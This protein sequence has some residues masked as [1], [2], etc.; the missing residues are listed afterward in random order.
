MSDGFNPQREICTEKY[1]VDNQDRLLKKQK[2][3]DKQNREKIKTRKMIYLN[4]R[5]K[6]DLN[7]C[8]ICKTRSRIRQALQGKTKSSSTKKFLGKDVETY[9]NGIKFQLT[10]EM[11]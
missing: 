3:Y 5:Y 2:L 7:F 8:S 9:R 11:T 4:I 10:P 6:T 1:N